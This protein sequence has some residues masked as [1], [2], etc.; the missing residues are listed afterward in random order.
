M[1]YLSSFR[2]RP[3]QVSITFVPGSD[4]ELRGQVEIEAS[5]PW[6]ETILWEVPLMATLS[7]IYFQIDNTDWSYEGQEGTT[8]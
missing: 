4:D 5:G 3:E 6:V 7:E 8:L 2:F 1:N